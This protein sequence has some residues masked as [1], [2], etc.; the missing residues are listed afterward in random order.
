[1]SFGKEFRR[2]DACAVQV[3]AVGTPLLRFLL[4][5]QLH[6]RAP[7]RLTPWRW[8]G[9]LC[10]LLLLS[11][12][13]GTLVHHTLAQAFGWKTP[14]DAFLKYVGTHPSVRVATALL[15][16]PILEEL[17]FR[18]FLSTNPLA[19]F[20]GLPFFVVY[21]CGLARVNFVH[22]A[23]RFYIA[24]Y[25]SGLWELVP[26]GVASLLLYRYARQPILGFFERHG[27]W[28][29]WASC[30]IFG[31][32]HAVDFTNGDVVWWAF[33]LTLP[34]FI[35]GVGF[36]YIR[37]SFGLR[38]SMLTHWAF[39]WLLVA[40]A[41]SSF[42]VA[43]EHTATAVLTWVVVVTMLFVLAYGLVGVARVARGLW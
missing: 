29:F 43:R 33:V 20:I 16:A 35:A 10:L 26:A 23:S 9:W 37:I 8:A 24:H 28:V 17:A 14:P 6:D 15:F 36:A 38:W 25:Y 30:V 2:S 19:I 13:A 3:A 31:A 21:V 7:E 27:A 4:H 32:G 41:W 42:A 11:A 39:D 18:A 34:Q 12:A 1:M 40:I 22:I 5:P